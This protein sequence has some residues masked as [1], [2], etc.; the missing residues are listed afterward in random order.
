MA[1]KLKTAPAIEPVSLDEI[2]NHLRLDLDDLT[3]DDLLTTL[4]ITAR[5]WC[6]SFQN[7]Q[8]T[9]A[10]WELWLD[11]WPLGDRLS[12]PLPPLQAVNSVKYYGTDNTE[13]TMPAD[14]YFV[15][16]KSEPG[17]LALAYGKTWPTTTL[18]PVNGICIEFD[19]GY[20]DAAASV[21]KRAK[22][23]MSLLIGHLYENREAGVEKALQE[24][25]FGVKS[26]LWQERVVPT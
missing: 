23:A 6:E 8:Y 19:A 26:L 10:T 9:T 14:D 1:L 13:Y 22:H 16:N 20:G 24:I 15:D 2:K 5:E 21:P 18:R 11:Q 12:I 25:P 7:R 17:R 4:I 3:E